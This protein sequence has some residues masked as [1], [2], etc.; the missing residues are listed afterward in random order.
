MHVNYLER[1]N[2]WMTQAP[3][4]DWTKL[5]SKELDHTKTNHSPYVSKYIK[6]PMVQRY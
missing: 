1:V 3:S 5:Y 6:Y 2:I 4:K